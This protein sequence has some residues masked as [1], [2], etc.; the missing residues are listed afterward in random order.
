ML[1]DRQTSITDAATHMQLAML[2]GTTLRAPEGDHDDRAMAY[3]LALAALRWRGALPDSRPGYDP[4]A[5]GETRQRT[6]SM[7][8]V[9]TE[10]GVRFQWRDRQPGGT[11]L[12]FR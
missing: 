10:T 7:D 12:T 8:L 2:D 5:T 1:R 9:P 11:D 6:G 3:M 4:F